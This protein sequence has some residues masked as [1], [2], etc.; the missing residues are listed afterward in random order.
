MCVAIERNTRV[1]DLQGLLRKADSRTLAGLA[2]G[3]RVLALRLE[4]L[5]VCQLADGEQLASLARDVDDE[6]VR[7]VG[8]LA[9]PRPPQTVKSAWGLRMGAYTIP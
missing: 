6:L 2:S 3:P 8:Q 4:V 1:A 9:R 5:G 7:H